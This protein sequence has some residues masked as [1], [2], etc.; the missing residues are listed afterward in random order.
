MACSSCNNVMVNGQAAF[1]KKGSAHVFCSRTCLFHTFPANGTPTKTCHRCHQAIARPQDLITAAVDVKGTMKDFCSVVC[2]VTFKSRTATAKTRPPAS[3]A[4]QKPCNSNV[5]C[6]LKSNGSSASSLCQKTPNV[7]EKKCYNC[8]RVITEPRKVILVPVDHCGTKRELCSGACLNSLKSRMPQLSCKTCCKRGN[9]AF[10]KTLDGLDLI[11]CTDACFV[12]YH[13]SNNIPVF[14]CDVCASAC[15]QKRLALKTEQLSKTVCGEVCLHRFKE[16]TEALQECRRCQTFHRM[17]DMVEGENDDG[18][19]DFFCSGRCMMVQKSLTLSEKQESAEDAEDVQVKPML[20]KLNCIKEE[21]VEEKLDRD[22]TLESTA[23]SIKTEAKVAEEPAITHGVAP[24]ESTSASDSDSS[25]LDCRGQPTVPV[26]SMTRC[27]MCCKTGTSQH[28]VVQK[29]VL[30]HLCSRPCFL[31]FCSFNSAPVCQSCHV[32]C[33]ASIVL[34][35]QG[36]TANLCS[37]ACLTRFKQE[38]RTPQPCSTCATRCLMSDMVEDKRGDGAL[39]LFCSSR[40]VIASKIQNVQSSDIRLRCDHCGKTALAAC[41]LAMADSSIRNFCSL[42]CAMTFKETQTAAPEPQA[43]SQHARCRFLQDP[44]DLPCASC[45]RSLTAA[46]QVVQAKGNMHFVCSAPCAQSFQEANSLT[47]QCEYCKNEQIA[48]ET[49]WIDD[50]EQH[51]CS[52]GCSFLFMARLKELWGEHCS[53]CAYCLSTTRTLVSDFYRNKMENFCSHECNTKYN[54]LLCHLARCDTCGHEGRLSERLPVPGHVRHFCDLKCLLHFCHWGASPSD[55]GRPAEGAAEPSPVILGVMSL[56]EA[57]QS[58]CPGAPAQSPHAEAPPTVSA[59]KVCA[60][61]A[62]QT[63]P[64]ELK[65]RSVLCTPLV[66][67]KGVWCRTP[68]M[69]SESQTDKPPNSG[70]PVP[71]PVYIPVP[72]NMYSQYTPTPLVLAL[73]VPVPI[74]LSAKPGDPARPTSQTGDGHVNGA[75]SSEEDADASGVKSRQGHQQVERPGIKAWKRWTQWRQSQT[76]LC[77]VSAPAV[78]L[79]EDILR[80]SPAEL[81]QGLACFVAEVKRSDGRPYSADR[82]LYLSLDIQKHLFDN[83]RTENL[84]FDPI[85]NKFS[86]VLVRTLRGFSPGAGLM[87]CVEEAFLWE[88]KQLGAYSPVILLNTLCYFCS[89]HFGLATVQQHRRLCFAHVASC[90]RTSADGTKT[91]CLRFCPPLPQKSADSDGVPAKKRKVGAQ[92]EILEVPE[93]KDN[94]LQC[95]VKFYEFYLSKCSDTS[96]QSTDALYLQPLR[97]CFPSSPVWFS[98]TPLDERTLET[99]LVRFSAVREL[100][101]DV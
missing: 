69:D 28:E 12:K 95:P 80:C 90:S 71:V 4:F 13:E 41:H 82:L 45:S 22:P 40:C 75:A 87:S 16:G 64:A 89:K 6:E 43:A 36:G 73:P 68:M 8:L 35:L 10:R 60:H 55:A 72:M 47:V 21:P 54:K 93:N 17:C 62:V 26:A 63:A 44:D 77:L 74:F 79:N 39:T 31:R 92:E 98:S 100:R 58:S 34:R 70:V 84:F 56:A 32:H 59:A 42:S 94:P 88:C 91:T 7:V 101:R 78:T 53:S 5:A 33:D 30:Y 57:L 81:S 49:K 19:L 76:N 96:R 48:R 52:E 99:M 85:Y 15:P 24:P 65:N 38:S 14:M 83:S 97:C 23:E 2:L 27:S 66:H 86:E 50:R 9:Y 11:F 67:N 20:P 61:A 18:V 3:S 46:P 37:L 25:R 29:G 1:Q 51:F